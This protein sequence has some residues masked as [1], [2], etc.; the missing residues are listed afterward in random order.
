VKMGPIRCPETS[1]NYYRTTPRNNPEELRSQLIYVRLFSSCGLQTHSHCEGNGHILQLIFTT[2]K[3][4]LKP[5]TGIEHHDGNGE[6]MH[7]HMR[8]Q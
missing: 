6:A 5:R 3:I 4:R 7:D 8:L 2:T 1:V